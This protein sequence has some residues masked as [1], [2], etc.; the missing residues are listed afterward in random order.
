MGVG[1][2]VITEKSMEERKSITR[3]GFAQQTRG[4]FSIKFRHMFAKQANGGGQ[5]PETKQY[6]GIFEVM[7]D[8]SLF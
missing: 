7:F 5:R 1:H 3:R 8:N 2:P 6:C 4:L